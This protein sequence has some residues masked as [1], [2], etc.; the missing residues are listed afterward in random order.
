MLNGKTMLQK[1][2]RKNAQK[3]NWKNKN[4]YDDLLAQLCVLMHGTTQVSHS[5]VINNVSQMNNRAKKKEDAN[6]RKASEHIYI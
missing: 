5:H 6:K 4:Q 2:K 3:E 1:M